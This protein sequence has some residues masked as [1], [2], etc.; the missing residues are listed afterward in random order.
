MTT[1]PR[2]QGNNRVYFFQKCVFSLY[3]TGMRDTKVLKHSM[4]TQYTC[5]YTSTLLFTNMYVCT[6][7]YIYSGQLEYIQF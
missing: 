2:R 3:K 6:N 5:A 4:V 1:M 7:V